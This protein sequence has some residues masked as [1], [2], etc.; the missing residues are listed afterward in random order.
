MYEVLVSDHI[1]IC[2]QNKLNLGE[3]DPQ[4]LGVD[5]YRQS[6]VNWN[7]EKHF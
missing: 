6:L 3:S 7:E 1:E 4:I 5:A 2:E